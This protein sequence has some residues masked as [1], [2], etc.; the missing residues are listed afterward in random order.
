[1]SIYS[2][3][4]RRL[5]IYRKTAYVLDPVAAS[6]SFPLDRQPSV[7]TYLQ[8]KV[9]GGTDNT[10]TVTISGNVDGSPDSEALV[11]SASGIKETEKRFESVS[12][13]V[14]SG[15]DDEATIPTIEIK[16]I[17]ADGSPQ[18]GLALLKSGV[19]GVVH[20]SGTEDHAWRATV[21]GSGQFGDGSLLLPY[22]SDVDLRDGD[23]VEDESTGEQWL[24][25]GKP[26]LGG[27]LRPRIIDA[28]IMARQEN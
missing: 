27:G 16:S 23:L 5:S 18:N 24:I 9:S 19:P 28:K 6:A 17:G 12:G 13:V 15:L 1:M 11:F 3:A 7:E 25:T 22:L 21:G 2:M 4:D 14:T 8:V 26:V 20:Y 10:G